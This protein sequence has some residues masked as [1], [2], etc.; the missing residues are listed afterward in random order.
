MN[1][2]DQNILKVYVV[3]TQ[4]RRQMHHKEYQNYWVL[5]KENISEKILR[6]SI[7][8]MRS[9][10]GIDMIQDLHFLY[11]GKIMKLRDIMCFM[12]QC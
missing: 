11:M 8:G 7:I 10:D 5:L 2:Q 1:I 9:L 4:R 3:Q 6:K 12:L